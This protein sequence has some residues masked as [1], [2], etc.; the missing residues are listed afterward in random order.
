MPISAAFSTCCGDPPMTAVR[1]AA[2]MEHAT[3]TSPVAHAQKRAYMTIVFTW[4]CKREFKAHKARKRTLA[5]DLGGRNAG[6]PLEEHANG[7]RRQKELLDVLL[8]VGRY[9]RQVVLEHFRDDYKSNE[10]QG[11]RVTHQSAGSAVI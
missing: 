5:A 11:S 4:R 9:E 1:A 7:C 8:V 10:W 2:A 3:P 6:A